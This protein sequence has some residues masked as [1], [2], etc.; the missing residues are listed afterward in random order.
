MLQDHSVV[1]EADV[2][3]GVVGLGPLLAQEVQ[4]ARGQHGELAVLD[5]LAQVRQPRLLALRV[6]LDDA[7]DTVHDGPLVLKA[8]LQHKGRAECRGCSLQSLTGTRHSGPGTEP[9]DEGLA[10]PASTSLLCK[11]KGSG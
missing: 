10:L 11:T 9:G 2:L 7:D 1:D 5:E 8:A 4:D 3:G 6:L